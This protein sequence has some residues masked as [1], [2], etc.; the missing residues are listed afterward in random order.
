MAES[1]EKSQFSQEKIEAD[2]EFIQTAAANSPLSTAEPFSKGDHENVA[3][4]DPPISAIQYPSGLRLLLLTIGLMAM[5]LTVALDNYII[6]TAIPRLTS[7]FKSLNLVGWTIGVLVYYLPFYFQSIL[8][9]SATSSG[10]L[11]LPYIMAL[12]ITPMIAGAMITIVG[13]YIPFLYVGSAIATAGAAL[14]FTLDQTSR[15]GQYIG[16]Q[17]LA[18]F[19]AG[20]C[21]QIPFTAVP[22]SVPPTELATAS[23][24]VA[25]CNSLGPVLAIT[26]GQA[27]FTNE[28]AQQLAQIPGVDVNAIVTSSN[29]L[30]LEKIVPP[31]LFHGVI[32]AMSLALT[33]TLSLAI[34]SAAAA[35]LCCFGLK[36]VKGKGKTK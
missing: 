12:L 9:H 36:W 15:P 4:T 1:T 35:F 28:F 7:D 16:Y 20:L 13:Y 21:R 25:F 11:T 31:Q 18:A 8:G 10:I 30:N 22:M 27:I 14:L 26:I 17:F 29:I 6:S 24:L 3:E 34:P 19:G 2:V 33:R 23:A 5:V 32:D